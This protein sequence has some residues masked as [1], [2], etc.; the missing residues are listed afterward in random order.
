MYVFVL[1]FPGFIG[2]GLVPAFHLSVV[3]SVLHV[4]TIVSAAFEIVSYIFL[5]SMYVESE[6]FFR[7]GVILYCLLFTLLFSEMQYF[8]CILY[9]VF[10]L[11]SARLAFFL[12]CGHS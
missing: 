10:V 7:F 3:A 1:S 2:F 11:I 5:A 4:I 9:C 12:L 8:F 6:S